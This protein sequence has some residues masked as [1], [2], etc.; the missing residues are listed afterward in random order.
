MTHSVQGT[1]ASEDVWT[2]GDAVG[3]SGY[4]SF[5]DEIFYA[6]LLVLCVYFGGQAVRLEDRHERM[7]R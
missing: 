7:G 6:L 1:L 5:H 3:H 4:Y 2:E